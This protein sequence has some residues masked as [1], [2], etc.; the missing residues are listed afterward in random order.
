MMTFSLCYRDFILEL[1]GTNAVPDVA[2]KIEESHVLDRLLDLP[3]Y[4]GI[5]LG[6]VSSRD[7]L[8]Q[9]RETAGLRHR[10]L[11]DDSLPGGY[12][13]G[14]ARQGTLRPRRATPRCE[15]GVL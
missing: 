10:D 4:R 5:Q 8:T 1:I 11:H 15:S 13:P 14:A 7:G 9:T 3:A 2:G 12:S 6:S